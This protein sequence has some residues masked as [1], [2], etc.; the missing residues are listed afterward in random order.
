MGLAELGSEPFRFLLL[1]GWTAN[2]MTA[3]AIVIWDHWEKA[4]RITKTLVGPNIHKQLKQ[5]Q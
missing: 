1:V 5:L 3:F 4:K 2:M